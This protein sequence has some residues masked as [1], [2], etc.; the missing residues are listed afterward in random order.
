[1]SSHVVDSDDKRTISASCSDVGPRTFR[2]LIG[3]RVPPRQRCPHWRRPRFP[4]RFSSATGEIY[5]GRDGL[6]G[7]LFG[8]DGWQT[9]CETKRRIF[10]AVEVSPALFFTRLQTMN[11]PEVAALSF[12]ASTRTIDFLST[13]GPTFYVKSATECTGYEL[14][15]YTHTHTHLLCNRYAVSQSKGP[16]DG[17]STKKGKTLNKSVRNLLKARGQNGRAVVDGV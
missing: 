17:E 4:S 7:K 10:F 11:L 14:L 2:R 3:A 13:G 15:R 16:A 1:V 8:T 9:R 12:S 5:G 6:I